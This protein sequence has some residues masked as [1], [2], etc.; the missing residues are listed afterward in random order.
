MSGTAGEGKL[1]VGTLTL[2]HRVPRPPQDEP[3]NNLDIESID[4]LGEAINDYKGG[5]LARNSPPPPG[6]QAAVA[7]R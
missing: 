7:F 6:D 5:E 4:A 1:Q 2:S 3:T